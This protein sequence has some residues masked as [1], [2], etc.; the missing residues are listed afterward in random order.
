M[1]VPLMKS[2]HE[3]FTGKGNPLSVSLSHSQY[4]KKLGNF[5]NTFIGINLNV[6]WDFQT[7]ANFDRIA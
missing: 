2:I 7:S 6:M 4:I 1:I 5:C 3:V